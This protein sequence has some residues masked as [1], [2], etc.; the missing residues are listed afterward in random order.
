MWCYQHLSTLPLTTSRLLTGVE[1]LF[2]V[3]PK[4]YFWFVLRTQN[5][6]IILQEKENLLRKI[7]DTGKAVD[8]AYVHRLIS[9]LFFNK[10]NEAYLDD[11]ICL[12]IISERYSWKLEK[13]MWLFSLIACKWDTNLQLLTLDDIWF[14]KQICQFNKN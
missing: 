14:E 5:F 7:K 13:K 12:H 6:W 9:Q 3:T 11:F 4:L 1:I 10:H 8:L 2:L